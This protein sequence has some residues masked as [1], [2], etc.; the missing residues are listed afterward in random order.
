MRSANATSVLCRP[1]DSDVMQ[2]YI[3]GQTRESNEVDVSIANFQG[4]A[5]LVSEVKVC[6]T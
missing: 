2:C 1:P 6:V 4:M 5:R 3:G